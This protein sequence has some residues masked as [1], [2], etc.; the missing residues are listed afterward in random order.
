MV[1]V[2]KIINTVME[3]LKCNVCN[4]EPGEK[5]KFMNRS[6]YKVITGIIAQ[7]F[8]VENKVEIK[9]RGNIM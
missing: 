9:I 6:T 1:C 4:N 5:R 2:V 8:S 7:F 3:Y